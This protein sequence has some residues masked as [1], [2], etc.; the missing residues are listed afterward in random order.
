MTPI[1]SI[2][3]VLLA[4]LGLFN[5]MN[6][7]KAVDIGSTAYSTFPLE[8]GSGQASMAVCDFNS[9]G[10][11]DVIIA[12]YTDNN[13]IAYQGNGKGKLIEV[14]RFP[15]GDSP[16][17]ISVSDINNDGN[18]DVAI[19]NHETS[20][21]TLLLGDGK[22]AFKKA[23]Q[24]PFNIDIK[25]HP[26]EVRLSD[27]DGDNKVDLIV[28][29]RTHEGLLVLKG[30]SN[31]SFQK[32]GK[33]INVGGDPYRGF[34]IN[35]INGDEALDFV[36]PNQN[37]IGVVINNNSNDMTFS[38]KK[39]SQ[40]GSPFAVELAEMNGDGNMDL[41]IATNGSLITVIPG[42]GNGNFLE[43][44]KTEIQSSS[45]AKQIAI[46]DINADGI[47]D[48]LVSNWSG[49]ILAIFGSKTSIETISFEHSS[50]PNPWGIALADLNNDGKSDFIIADGDSKSA[51]VY[52]SQDISD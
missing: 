47:K 24:S 22:G 5:S 49:Q 13:I 48:A 7:A 10:Y 29:S 11:Q 44:E 23:Q 1:K 46:G 12:N 21:V 6:S 52:V 39:L 16:S 14:G 45:G 50:I 9:D 38:L 37:H 15:V 41:V 40:T 30:L 31:G 8:V 3:Y 20:Y 4:S 19:A 51:V 27:I 42:D 2:S 28:D 43:E 35:D 18:S 25:P 33:V 32:P 17:G 26:H 36:T 34:A